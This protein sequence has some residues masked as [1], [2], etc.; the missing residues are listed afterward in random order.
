V[1][2]FA[3]EV[4]GGLVLAADALEVDAAGFD[5]LLEGVGEVLEVG[6]PGGGVEL[7]DEEAGVVVD[8]DAGEA[9][10][11]AVEEAEGVGVAEVEG[12]AAQGEGLADAQAPEEGAGVLVLAGGEDAEGDRGVGGEEGVADR[13]R[14]WPEEG[15]EVAGAGALQIVGTASA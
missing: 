9:V 7:E 13:R 1:G 12:G 3:A 15:D 11:L 14:P 5:E 8:D 4:A 10:A 2:S 6:E